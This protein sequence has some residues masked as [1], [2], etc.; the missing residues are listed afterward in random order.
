[1]KTPPAAGRLFLP[2]L[3]SE[4]KEDMMDAGH[5]AVVKALVQRIIELEWFVGTATQLDEMLAFIE[6]IY[7]RDEKRPFA[8]NPIALSMNLKSA[9][10][11]LRDLGIIVTRL[12]RS[13]EARL[14]SITPE[15]VDEFYETY[16]GKAST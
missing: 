9:T 15:W 2:I 12:P 3:M 4:D 14:L 10:K 7:P 13:N 6:L 5:K 1:M 11:R 8:N 16:F